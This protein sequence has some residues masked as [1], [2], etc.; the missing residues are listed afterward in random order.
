M[1]YTS[2][3]G[4]VFLYFPTLMIRTRFLR[5]AKNKIRILFTVGQQ[6]IG[7][8]ILLSNSKDCPP[9]QEQIMQNLRGF[10]IW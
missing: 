3:I 6:H 10:S 5:E 1:N 7:S 8:D 9:G 2:G 4:I